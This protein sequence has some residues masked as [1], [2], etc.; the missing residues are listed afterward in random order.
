MTLWDPHHQK[1]CSNVDPANDS[2]IMRSSPSKEMQQCR[3]SLWLYNYEILTIKRSC[4]F[5]SK[6]AYN[7]THTRLPHQRGLWE[8]LQLDT[9][10][11][12]Q[13]ASSLP[14]KKLISRLLIKVNTSVHLTS[15]VCGNRYSWMLQCGNLGPGYEFLTKRRGNASMH[16][17]LCSLAGHGCWGL[18]KA[19]TYQWAL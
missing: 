11:K 13:A 9:A 2:I 15:S 16:L 12:I 19:C 8:S 18:S 5:P 7:L 4:L 6:S 17:P 10:V 1:K 3:S 14:S